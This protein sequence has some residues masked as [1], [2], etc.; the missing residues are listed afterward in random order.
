MLKKIIK[1]FSVT[2]SYKNWESSEEYYR[3]IFPVIA[4]VAAII[5]LVCYVQ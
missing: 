4:I 3:R 5:V 1:F 2:E